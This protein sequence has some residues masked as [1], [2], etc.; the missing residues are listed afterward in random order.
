[1][2]IKFQI[3]LNPAPILF[4]GLTGATDCSPN[5]KRAASVHD[6]ADQKA[7]KLYIAA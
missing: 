2:N 6:S 7:A 1:M 3:S 5:L 4:L